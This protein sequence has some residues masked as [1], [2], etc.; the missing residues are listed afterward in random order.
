MK[1]CYSL[2]DSPV[3]VK[4]N[5]VE[6]VAESKVAENESTCGV[7]DSSKAKAQEPEH[8]ATRLLEEECYKK[9][10]SM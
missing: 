4:V 10:I 1:H 8:S 2:L 3:P 7:D 9:V 6:K 5:V